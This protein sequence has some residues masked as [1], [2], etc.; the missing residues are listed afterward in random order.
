[1]IILSRRQADVIDMLFYNS[2]KLREEMAYLAKERVAQAADSA[3]PTAKQA[4][5]NLAPVPYAMGYEKPELWLQAEKETWEK[6]E[7]TIIGDCMRR[8]YKLKEVWQMT[9]VNCYV[10]D[11]TYFK[12]REEF[13]LYAA[14]MLAKKGINLELDNGQWL[15]DL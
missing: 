12:Y 5:E 11:G 4:V 13:V 2:E 15:W 8:R 10:S 3:D 7:G 1:M 9:V 14:L 6:Y